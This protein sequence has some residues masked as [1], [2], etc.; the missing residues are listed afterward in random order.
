METQSLPPLLVGVQRI[1]CLGDS[2][3]EG[4]DGPN[5]YV[6]LLRWKLQ[7]RVPRLKIINAGISGHRSNDMLARFDRDVLRH[8]P[9]LVTISVGVND[10]WHGFDEDHP[11][12]GGPAGIPV[13]AFR[14]NV[15]QMVAKA[16]A[17][18]A[19]VVILS[20]T[21]IGEDRESPE[22]LYAK[23][24]NEAL[25][26]IATLSGCRYVDY[27]AAFWAAIRRHRTET[28]RTDNCLTTDGVHMN[29]KGYALMATELITALS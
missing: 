9:D 26:E 4:G 1:V 5:G 7:D 23:P 21:P 15:E 18:A 24:Y 3:T 12:G 19:K 25:R 6:G 2:I 11:E 16:Q 27:Q 29:A 20:G 8:K 28:G 13:D 14:R 10:V 17:G 22:N